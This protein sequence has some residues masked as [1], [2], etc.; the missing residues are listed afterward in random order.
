MEY[1]SWLLAAACLSVLCAV[2]SI[3]LLV[4]SRMRMRREMAA[5]MCVRVTREGKEE[6]RENLAGRF[7]ALKK[8]Y[9]A[10][11]FACDNFSRNSGKIAGTAEELY[12]DGSFSA[13]CNDIVY[14]T[15]MCEGGAIYRM[16]QQY[17]LTP[18]ELRTCCFIY[19][20]FRW[21]Q[22]CTVESLTENAYNVRCSRIRKK[23]SLGK[24]ERI[25][26]FIADYC[27]RNI[28]LSGQ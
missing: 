20:G 7:E 10:L 16:G 17:R 27:R 28:T 1:G 5:G 6:L 26:D 8:I 22:T 18:L 3:L 2:A 11:Y 25:P 4:S 23:L 24:D 14:V 21:Q 15:N 9:G 12:K 13:L 19:W